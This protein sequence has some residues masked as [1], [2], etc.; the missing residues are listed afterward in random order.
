MSFSVNKTIPQSD[1]LLQDIKGLQSL[2]DAKMSLYGDV[3]IQN[4]LEWKAMGMPVNEQ[5]LIATKE[6]IHHL[7][8]DLLNALNNECKKAQDLVHDMKALVHSPMGE[9]LM[10]SILAGLEFIAE[11]STLIGFT[12]L[13]IVN[14]CHM[15]AIIYGQWVSENLEHI[16]DKSKKNR[17]YTTT[18]R[19]DIRFMHLLETMTR[20]L[21]ALYTLNELEIS[22]SY[23]SIS[24]VDNLTSVLV[25]LTVRAVSMIEIHRANEAPS[26]TVAGNI[27]SHPQTTFI[28]MGE[29]LLTFASKILELSGQEGTFENRIKV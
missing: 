8:N 6:W 5:L 24:Y 18:K 17:S 23:G 12:S 19:T 13:R 27:M 1:D 15:L 11:A 14:E 3:L 28:Y 29:S 20:I 25:E 10:A 4:G 26:K 21:S 7:C 9:K 22:P 2:L 16:N